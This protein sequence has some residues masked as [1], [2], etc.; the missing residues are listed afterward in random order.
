[1]ANPDVIRIAEFARA[2][3]LKK[4]QVNFQQFERGCGVERA[5][6]RGF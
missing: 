3:K 6:D 4:E 5:V 2:R 1:L